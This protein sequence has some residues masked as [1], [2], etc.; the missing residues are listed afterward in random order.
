[1][2]MKRFLP[3]KKVLDS[4]LLM[5]IVTKGPAHGYALANDIEERVGWVPSQTAIYNS[6]KAMESEG[7]VTSE[8]RIESGRVQKIYSATKKG[9]E[10]FKETHQNMKRM[11]MKNFR[12]FFSLMEMIGDIE[13]SEESKV[14]QKRIHSTLEEIKRIPFLTLTLLKEAPEETVEVVEEYLN[15]LMKIAEKKKIKLPEENF[16]E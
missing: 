16:E 11:I 3:P 12:R 6:L 14:S 5:Q 7:I 9:K 2:L 15:T 4:L 13:S 10:L 8:E 1:M